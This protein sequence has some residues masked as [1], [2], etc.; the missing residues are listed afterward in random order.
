[1][2]TVAFLIFAPL[3]AAVSIAL[4]VLFFMSVVAIVDFTDSL[5]HI[6]WPFLGALPILVIF[7][8]LAQGPLRALRQLTPKDS[9]IDVATPAE[10][11]WARMAEAK[12]V[13]L[14][15]VAKNPPPEKVR[16]RTT[17]NSDPS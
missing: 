13:F 4:I 11:Y 1:M 10:V 5:S 3:V 8:A 17:K 15:E 6:L 16:R 7:A 9:G 14:S 12:R 2:R